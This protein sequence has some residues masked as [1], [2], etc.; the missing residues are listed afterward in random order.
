LGKVLLGELTNGMFITKGKIPVY[1][2][3]LKSVSELDL[4][5]YW[6]S[7][8]IELSNGEYNEMT[9]SYFRTLKRPDQ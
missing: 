2:N 1:K 8:K 4:L 6:G 9:R 7:E 5:P 3:S